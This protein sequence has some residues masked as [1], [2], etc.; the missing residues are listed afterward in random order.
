MLS[1]GGEQQQFGTAGVEWVN[2][3]L[4]DSQS[5]LGL[6]GTTQLHAPPAHNSS[7]AGP[8]NL[9]IFYLPQKTTT[10]TNIFLVEYAICPTV[11]VCRYTRF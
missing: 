6:W 4:F 8:F 10:K 9:S 11:N 3:T 1:S 2:S 7:S 5:K